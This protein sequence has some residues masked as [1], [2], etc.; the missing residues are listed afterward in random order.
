MA[1]S[2]CHEGDDAEGASAGASGA[3][4]K[5]GRGAANQTHETQKR[6]DGTPAASRSKLTTTSSV[7]MPSSVTS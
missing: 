5:Q 7:S 2:G 3:E 4:R 6:A 1:T